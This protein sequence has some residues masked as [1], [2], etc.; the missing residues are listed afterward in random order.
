MSHNQSNSLIYVN[1]FEQSACVPPK[2]QNEKDGT[3]HFI[4]ETK[5]VKLRT[6]TLVDVSCKTTE[7][8]H[9]N[10]EPHNFLLKTKFLQIILRV[11]NMTSAKKSPTRV[12]DQICA[13]TERYQWI[14]TE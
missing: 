9:V 11:L 4:E 14:A 1:L 2:Y 3:M 8:L 10:N 5:H 12:S 7:P 13:A 6:V